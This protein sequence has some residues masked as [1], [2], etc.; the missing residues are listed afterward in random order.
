M[1]NSDLVELVGYYTHLVHDAN[2]F[3]QDAMTFSP[4]KAL[5]YLTETNTHLDEPN[6]SNVIKALHKYAPQY[7]QRVLKLH[8]QLTTRVRASVHPSFVPSAL[9]D[10]LTD[11]GSEKNE[12]N[13]IL[14]AIKKQYQSELDEDN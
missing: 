3:I 12:L 11:M 6:D 9:K 5:E 14:Q 7:E 2:N 8:M 13:D 1:T 10:Y 4:Q